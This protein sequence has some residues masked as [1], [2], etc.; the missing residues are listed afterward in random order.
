MEPTG[1]VEKALDVLFHLHATG[2]PQGLGAI[3]RALGLPK[4][5]AHRLLASLARRGLVEQDTEGRYQPGIAL[6]ALGLGALEREPVVRAA[7]PVLEA[8]ARA[9]GHTLFLTALRGGA[10]TVLDMAEGPGFLRAAPRIGETVPVHATAVGRLHLALEP[11]R[12]PLARGA[13]ARFTERTRT[14]RAALAQEVARVRAQ[15]WAENREEWTRGLVVVAAP[16]LLGGRLVASLA[17]GA[18][19][20]GL[21][22]RDVPDVAARLVDAARRVAERLEGRGTNSS[23]AAAS[24]ATPQRSQGAGR[25]R[26]GGSR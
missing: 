6:V 21:P 7:R 23:A 15:G 5:S 19:S 13:L 26:H 17:I 18:P 12:V 9:L 1:T 10:I 24:A 2:E 25:R 22:E 16:V 8:E 11:E 14:D 4:S 3:A 20:A